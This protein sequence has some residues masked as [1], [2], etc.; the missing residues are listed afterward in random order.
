LTNRILDVLKESEKLK[1]DQKWTVTLTPKA[2]GIESYPAR[3]GVFS[4]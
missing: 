3:N 4:S 1:V 2:E